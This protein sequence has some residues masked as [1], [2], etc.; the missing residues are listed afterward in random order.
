MQNTLSTSNNNT[1]KRPSFQKE[2]KPVDNA[3]ITT[4]NS[5]RKQLLSS[6]MRKIKK[7]MY[8]KTK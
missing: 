3:S 7:K 8:L 5:K 2:H 1:V 4:I 6:I